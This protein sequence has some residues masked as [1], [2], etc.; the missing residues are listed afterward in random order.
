MTLRRRLE[1][2]STL[3]RALLVWACLCPALGPRTAIAQDL[4]QNGGCGDGAAPRSGCGGGGIVHPAAPGTPGARDR[5]GRAA[6][7]I[8]GPADDTCPSLPAAQLMI[9][10]PVAIPADAAD[11]TLSFWFSRFGQELSP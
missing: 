1:P 3:L 11:L 6:A 10:Q 2:T 4:L 7:R 9:V 8:G 5:A